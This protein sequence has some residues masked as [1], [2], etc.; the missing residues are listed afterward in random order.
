M[1]APWPDDEQPEVGIVRPDAAA[2]ADPLS[3]ADV[4]V[5]SGDLD[6]V[7]AADPSV[8]VAA[9]EPALTGI[10]RARP[11]V[12]VLPVG[13]I[14]GIES[15]D[16]THLSEALAAVLEGDVRV[17]PRTILAAEVDRAGD[18]ADTDTRSRALFDVTLVTDEPARIS[19][20]GV[21]SRGDVVA[22]FRADG[23]VVA[24]PAGSH[25]YASAIEAPQ[26]SAAVD[27]VAVA[28]I[29]PFVTQTRRWVLPDD[30]VVLTVERDEGNVTLVADD[31]SVASVAV[32]AR[33]TVSADGTLPTLV[34]PDGA[35]EMR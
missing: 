5:V 15:V 35:L 9:G 34:V 7:L 32:G 6:T 12:P 11:G 21:R 2:L 26:V 14:P 4:T 18:A 8:L 33:V 1:D 19:E 25:G 20:Y 31:R 17:R 13:P 23:V 27:A 10:A 29:A 22:T 28:P 3:T 16:R 30:D 24:T